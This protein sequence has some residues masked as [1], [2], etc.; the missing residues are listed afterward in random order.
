MYFLIS[1]STLHIKHNWIIILVLMFDVVLILLLLPQEEISAWNRMYSY[2]FWL[3]WTS[4]SCRLL[5]KFN[6]LHCWSSVQYSAKHSAPMHVAVF[7]LLSAYV[8]V[9]VHAFMHW[10]TMVFK[11]CQIH[12]PLLYFFKRSSQAIGIWKVYLLK[13]VFHYGRIQD[14]GT[15]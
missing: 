5:Y 3:S 7:I 4:L 15:N 2:I 11:R 14:I 10:S 12:V 6:F 9:C 13:N 8:R 1:Y